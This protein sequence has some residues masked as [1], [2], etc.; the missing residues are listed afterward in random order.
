[1]S[2]IHTY[3]ALS[4]E[5]SEPFDVIITGYFAAR[6]SIFNSILSRIGCDAVNLNTNGSLLL[7]YKV[8][9]DLPFLTKRPA[10]E[11]SD[12]YHYFTKGKFD[13]TKFMSEMQSKYNKLEKFQD[14]ARSM[15]SGALVS[16][17][18][19]VGG[20]FRMNNTSFGFLKGR[21]V[22]MFPVLSDKADF[23]KVPPEFTEL[24]MSQYAELCKTDED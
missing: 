2:V 3:W 6:D 10:Y 14:T 9:Q 22:M 16:V 19:S 13:E 18:D 8:K 24:S 23:S 21:L 12:G 17:M 15:W 7:T 1:M 4:K 5:A 20:S 11:N